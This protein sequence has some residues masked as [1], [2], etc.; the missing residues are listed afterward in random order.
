MS[1]LPFSKTTT[2]DTPITITIT[3]TMS[4]FYSPSL[5]SIPSSLPASFLHVKTSLCVET[6]G[7]RRALTPCR[8]T[9]DTSAE[10]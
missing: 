7:W 3:T 6:N 5:P 8:K 10:T 4:P 1:R 2:F 9:C